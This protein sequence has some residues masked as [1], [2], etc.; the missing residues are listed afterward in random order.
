MA[1]SV[2]AIK[3]KHL[4]A[5]R[6]LILAII[7]L[8][9]YVVVPQLG[10]FKDSFGQAKDAHLGWL[11]LGVI[12]TVGTYFAAACQYYLS[13]LKPLK[14]GLTFAV[15]CASAFTNRLLP[16]GIGGI[17]LNVAYLKRQHHSGTQAGVVVAVNNLLGITSDVIVV[18]IIASVGVKLALHIDVPGWAFYSAAAIVAS[19]LV[20]VL[21]GPL[22]QKAVRVLRNIAGNFLRYRQRPLKLA[23]ALAAAL[24]LTLL[25][26]AALYFSMKSLGWDLSAAQVFLVYIGSVVVAT[27]TP[28]PGGLVGAEAALTAGFV[29]YGL[30]ASVGLAIALVYRLITYWLPLVVGFVIFQTLTHKKI[31]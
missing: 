25:Y 3:R 10:D 1:S 30:P 13:A 15:E 9:L 19:A 23:G 11:L 5:K 8:M 4:T 24:V 7:L 22:R 31:I 18:A 16:A 12:A 20:V 2:A 14:L 29:A 21:A 26:A 17:S 28:T 27:I 6:L